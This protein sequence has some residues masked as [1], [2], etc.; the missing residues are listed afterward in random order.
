MSFVKIKLILLK[1]PILNKLLSPLKFV[2]RYRFCNINDVKMNLTINFGNLLY[3]D[4][5]IK[6]EEFRGIFYI[7]GKSDL[8]K[9]IIINNTY[10]PQLSATCVSNINP[11]RDAID[12]GANIGF[13]TVLFSKIL[14]GRRILSIEPTPNALI[15]LNKNIKLNKIE[16]KVIVFSGVV[17]DSS[18]EREIKIIFG[19][20]EYSSMGEMIHPSILNS[21]FD[22]IKVLSKTIDELVTEN[23]LDPGFI[24]ID[25]E[26]M[27]HIV[28]K[29]MNNVLKYNKPVILA[30]LSDPL[31]KRNGSSSIE[32][33]NQ[34]KSYGYKITDP[35]FKKLNPGER[36][37]G[38][39]LCIP[40]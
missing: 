15:R 3:E 17:S 28:I 9:R 20:E 40:L 11:N 8:F 22:K 37:Y 10:E 12:V 18:G 29:G 5:I 6:V 30:E 26:G 19:R 25:V 27:E 2:F 39:I 36:E 16:E 7:G 35:L 1:F 34:I 13:H 38:D 31:L 14:N 32:V 23:N 24:K 4:P 21:K 33:I